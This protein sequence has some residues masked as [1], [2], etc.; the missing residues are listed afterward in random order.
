MALSTPLVTL[1]YAL[2]A[3]CPDP[4]SPLA[5]QSSGHNMG[6]VRQGRTSETRGAHRA[7]VGGEQ[8]EITRED[9]RSIRKIWLDVKRFLC[10]SW[11][12]GALGI[13]TLVGVVNSLTLVVTRA[14][15]SGIVME[16][17]VEDSLI[18]DTFSKS[19]CSR[20]FGWP[21]KAVKSLNSYVDFNI[22]FC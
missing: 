20:F 13:L 6:T 14:S 5:N 11:W 2:T 8:V 17:K 7:E 4:V 19:F 10:H 1:Y 9:R 16:V 12:T 18:E 15:L 3:A 21:G 22:T